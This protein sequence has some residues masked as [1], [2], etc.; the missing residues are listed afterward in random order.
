VAAAAAAP[1]AGKAADDAKE[2]LKKARADADRAANDMRKTAR[3]LAAADAALKAFVKRMT[4]D[5]KLTEQA[6][7]KMA[8]TE[9]QLEGRIT[10]L[11]KALEVATAEETRTAGLL[12]DAEAAASAA[13]VA[14]KQAAKAFLDADAALKA[15]IE[16]DASAKRRDKKRQ[17]PISV[18]VSLK[19]KKIYV[20]QGYEPVFEGP[21]AIADPEKPIGTH[22]FTAMTAKDD[23]TVF[24][25]TVVSVPTVPAEK[26]ESKKQKK[27][28]KEREATV[29]AVLPASY[30]AEEQ[31]AE[32]ALARIEIPADVREIV[33]DSLRPSSSLLVSDHGLSSEFGEFTDFTVALR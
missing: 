32:K 10:E 13:E 23:R 4:T 8:E 21:V 25:W 3:D 28:D 30:A 14:R 20:R 33:A 2:A 11:T 17:L 5:R 12:K 16:S 15:A 9:D 1:L 22:I 18:F 6:A 24:D 7:A 27:K 29:A 26:A 31:T 19:T